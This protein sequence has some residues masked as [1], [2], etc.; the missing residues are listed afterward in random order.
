MAITLVRHDPQGPLLQFCTDSGRQWTVSLET[1]SQL[2]G[3]K[4]RATLMDWVQ[5]MAVSDE[6]ATTPSAHAHVSPWQRPCASPRDGKCEIE[7]DDEDEERQLLL[8][9][10]DDRNHSSLH[11]MTAMPLKLF[12]EGT[13]WCA[14]AGENI[15][16]GVAGFGDSVNEAVADLAS[17]MQKEHRNWLEFVNNYI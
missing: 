9:E 5:E 15:T 12:L 1:L 11:G 2:F 7:D 14:L 4:A 13:Q 3:P 17:N 10:A 16:V 8:E 6:E